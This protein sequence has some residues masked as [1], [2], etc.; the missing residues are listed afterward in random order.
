VLARYAQA[1]ARELGVAEGRVRAWVAYMIL[2]GMLERAADGDAPRF[3]VKGGVALE[4]RLR[5]RARATKDIDVV[6]LDPRA[7]LADALEQALSGDAYQGFSF[8]RKGQPLLL[9]SGAVNVE[10]AVTYRGQPWTSISVDIARA[11]AGESEVEWVEAIV[12]TEAFGVTGP[13]A[14]PC[15]PLR[16]HVAQKLHGTTLP[17]RPGKQNERFRDLIDLLLLEALFAHDYLALREACELVFRS[18]NTHPWPPNLNALPPHWAEP[19]T[20][21]SGELLLPERDLETALVR[22]RTFVARIINGRRR[23]A[24][25]DGHPPDGYASAGRARSSR[26]G[27]EHR[28]CR[29]CGRGPRREPLPQ[30]AVGP[31]VLSPR[32]RCSRA[33]G[34]GPVETRARQVHAPP[35][36]RPSAMLRSGG[37]LCRPVSARTQLSQRRRGVRG[38]PARGAQTP[39]PCP[40]AGSLTPL[41]S[42][43]LLMMTGAGISRVEIACAIRPRS[44]ERFRT[45]GPRDRDRMCARFPVRNDSI[46]G[47]NRVSL[48]DPIVREHTG[49][50]K[51]SLAALAAPENRTPWSHGGVRGLD[52]P[53]VLP[54]GWQLPK[55]RGER[56]DRT[57]SPGTIRLSPA[58]PGDLTRALR[59]TRR[60]RRPASTS[61]GTRSHLRAGGAR[62]R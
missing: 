28:R 38:D 57:N 36:L 6:L 10:I 53:G 18:R 15:L 9:D 42:S 19:F 44:G 32:E 56:S 49:R 34:S 58:R 13:G 61:R 3:I 54:C 4:L 20:R 26:A 37:A 41:V 60:P 29:P 22:L 7:D 46:V 52:P 48:P 25:Q 16:F 24:R 17:P 40:S 11:E 47:C 8:R 23:P 14:L 5:D 21:L 62:G 12:L 27:A 33:H 59:T 35:D 50:V 55:R 39:A 31:S 43:S 1:Y 45:H 2:A 51:A 30:G